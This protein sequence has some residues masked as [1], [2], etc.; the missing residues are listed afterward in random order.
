[1]RFE[2]CIVES[3]DLVFEV[4]A[5]TEDEAAGIADDMDATEAVRDSFRSRE[6][7]WTNRL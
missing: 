6:H 5:E 1:M 3:R 2:V 4:E 7:E